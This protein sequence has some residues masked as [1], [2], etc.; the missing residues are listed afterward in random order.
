LHFQRP[1]LVIEQLGIRVTDNGHTV[2]DDDAQTINCVM[3]WKDL[4]LLRIFWCGG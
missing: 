3:D 1:L 2:I 4:R